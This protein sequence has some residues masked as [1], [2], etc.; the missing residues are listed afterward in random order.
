M[1]GPHVDL[2]VVGSVTLVV[3]DHDTGNDFA[4]TGIALPDGDIEALVVS[5]GGR[6][7]AV[8]GED[9]LSGLEPA[10]QGDTPDGATRLSLREI[11]VSGSFNP[12]ES[13]GRTAGR[14]GAPRGTLLVGGVP[15]R[16]L[17][18]TVWHLVPA[19]VDSSAVASGLSLVPAPTE[20]TRGAYL[21]QSAGSEAL[22]WAAAPPPA[23]PP[24]GLL[25]TP[26]Q[27]RA[28]NGGSPERDQLYGAVLAAVSA[29]VTAR[30]GWAP[31]TLG[32]LPE[33]SVTFRPGRP[34]RRLSLWTAAGAWPWR[35][36]SAVAVD[37]S[38]SG[39]PDATYEVGGWIVGSPDGGPW[40]SL[41]VLDGRADAAEPCW[42][43]WPG[44]VTVTGLPGHQAVRPDLTELVCHCARE[45]LDGHKAG[46]AG[47]FAALEDGVRVSAAGA[48]WAQ[49][50]RELSAG[51]PDRVGLLPAGRRAGAWA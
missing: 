44:S 29:H 21:R 40:R 16:P 34:S 36:V 45:I 4:D 3:P 51:R 1:A 24:A 33:R 11:G 10:S 13:L 25:A 28:R 50:R 20:A 2:E 49:L 5:A 46:A 42:P 6:T 32:P 39:R 43:G 41:L 30:L 23:P 8:F 9:R 12:A 17:E 38:G 7:T 15:P 18:V 35:S 37:R 47:V 27:Y 48:I 14:E 19:G 31:G 22:E 26:E